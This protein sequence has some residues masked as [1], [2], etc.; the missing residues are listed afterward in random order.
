MLLLIAGLVLFLGIH[1]VGIVAEPWRNAMAAKN[2]AVWKIGYTAISLTGFALL[3]Y[4]YGQARM[5]P[6]W[7]WAPPPIMKAVS[8][9]L[10]LPVFILFLASFLRGK[11]STATKHPQLLAVKLWATAH[12]IAN[13][14]LADLLLFGGFLAWA[15]AQRISLK[16]RTPRATPGMA[17]SM[18]GDIGAVIGGLGIYVLFVVWAHEFLIGIRPFG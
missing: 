5:D 14:T 18:A 8:A 4:G 2:E 10:L 6:I 13:G 16:R 11:I 7:L 9:V 15:V 12:L 1:S 3:C 17:P